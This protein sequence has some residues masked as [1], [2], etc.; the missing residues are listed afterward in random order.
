MVITGVTDLRFH[1]PMMV[2]TTRAV[3]PAPVIMQQHLA[4]A[5]L[6]V[7]SHNIAGGTLYIS[8]LIRKFK[9]DILC[10]QEVKIDSKELNVIVNRLNYVGESNLC[11]ANPHKPGTAVVWRAGL[12]VSNPA[13][14]C[15][16]PRRA[17]VL[18]MGRL[19]IVNVYA[20]SGTA[21]R[22]E[23]E[24][25]F[26]GELA[27][28]VRG[29]GPEVILVGDW[30]CVLSPRDV[31]RDYRLKYSPA[32]DTLVQDFSLSD[33]FS[34]LHPD[35]REFTFYRASVTRSRL[36]R[37]YLSP[38]LLPGLTAVQHE[39]GLSDHSVLEAQFLIPGGGGA[40][41]EGKR[42]SGVWRLNCS[43]LTDEPF[44]ALAKDMWLELQEK[45]EEFG[46]MADWWEEAAKP[47]LRQLC[48]LYSRR[49]AEDRKEMKELVYGQLS[50]ALER[51]N[52]GLVALL[53]EQLRQL[54]LYEQEGIII[55]SRHQQEAEEERAGLF[56]AGKEVKNA[57]KNGLERLKVAR[58]GGG[59]DIIEEEEKIEEALYRFNDALFNARLDGNL[60]ETGVT[61]LPQL[62]LHQDEFLT[63]LPKISEA[64]GR[65]L[66]A[67][68]TVEEVE[69]Y[70]KQME[71][72]KSPGEDGLPKELYTALWDVIGEDVV[73]ML[74]TV[75]DRELLS[76][77]GTRGLTRLLSKLL[78]LAIPDV[79]E[80]RPV[81]LL[82]TDYKLLSG[83][84][85]GRARRVLP[86]VITSR[87]LAT[88]GQDIMEGVHGLLSAL[89]YIDRKSRDG[90]RYGALLAL[91]D[92]VKAFDRVHVAYLDLVLEHMN[93]PQKFRAW[94]Q[95]LHRGAT[96]RI[97]FR[98]GKLSDPIRIA[99]SERQGDPWAM[100][101]YIL[102][103]EPFLRAL[104]KAVV[105]VTLGMPHP[106][107]TPNPA[108]HTER[109]PGYCDDYAIIT[110]NVQDLL[111]VD[112]ISRRYEEQSGA[113]LSR[114][115]KSKVIFLGEWQN[116]DKRPPLPVKYLKEVKEGKILGF[117]VSASV[118]ETISRTWEERIRKLRG[119]LIEWRNRDLPTLHQ[120]SQVVAT[121]LV[122]TIWYTAQVIPLH[123]R[124]TKQ[125]DSEI[126]RFL[127]RGR[128]TMGRLT[129]AELSHPVREGGLGM[130]DTQR[131]ADSLFLKE[132]CRMLSRKKSG[133]RHISYW[134]GHTLADRIRLHDG[135]KS[136]TQAPKLYLHMQKLLNQSRE[137]W[138]ERE[139]LAQSAKSLYT[140]QC[141][142]LPVQRLQRRN[143]DFNMD[144]VWARLATPVLGV[145]ARHILFL[146]ANQLMRNNE[147]MFERWGRGEYTCDH[148]PDPD[149]R[150]AGQ[151]Q[152][153]AHIFQKC[154]RV[155]EPW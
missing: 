82:N 78:G 32:L 128:I 41:E 73:K 30:N 145:K 141:L 117:N 140:R 20:P 62:H 113:L 36:D 146:L 76:E 21:C 149:G 50:M 97:I 89:T 7:L 60:C 93:F 28:T 40:R 49:A 48:Q 134:L 4:G 84:L 88:P 153:V 115:K 132:T 98:N 139:L 92:M 72:G 138:S 114:N 154:A 90:V 58:E 123:R 15:V 87:Q 120:R 26:A 124:Y 94:I 44:L 85:T 147:Y 33:A 5:P 108:A 24:E 77:S 23:R 99:V 122:S 74:Q 2:T 51:Q 37:L 121:Y 135:P 143:P 144:P 111:T 27:L 9:P 25:L 148:S 102:Q 95:M 1:I 13:T 61:T 80:M 18:Q 100:I 19:A 66:V 83:S 152:S 22:K 91:Y 101:G 129:L 8:E 103:F 105:G 109:G 150:C 64:S 75:L 110:S 136:L 106:G 137:V 46:D 130:T 112:Q 56:H 67:K 45:Q 12:E 6:R 65:R 59:F 133:F 55:R 142:D 53:K 31:E 116:A 17:Q 68:L 43:I 69:D 81:T 34:S 16:E 79:T 10:L 42:G 155:V 118:K 151:P 119:K 96:T 38:G 86:E 11:P 57:A 39:P 125:I 131:K 3:P 63:D 54:L 52:W 107:M 47:A 104:E 29:L 127:F 35:K 126:S 71:N 70:L 14:K